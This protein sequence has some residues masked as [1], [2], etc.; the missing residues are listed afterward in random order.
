MLSR[1]AHRGSAGVRLVALV[2]ELCCDD[3]WVAQPGTYVSRFMQHQ[4]PA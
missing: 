4:L 2:V 1:F 3:T